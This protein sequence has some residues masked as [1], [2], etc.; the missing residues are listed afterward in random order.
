MTKGYRMGKK[1]GYVSL[2][3]A[4]NLVD[5]E[6]MLGLLRDNGYSITEDLSEADLIV[7]NTCT[8]IEKA[9]AES[10]NT[11]LEVAQYKEDGTCKGLIV[12]G[13]LSQQYQDELFQEIPEIDALIGTGA[14]DQVMVA[15][16]AIEH[17]N[18]SCIM[19]NITNIYDERM[20][21]IQTTPRYSAYVKIA[22][23]CNN[24]CTFCIPQS[25]YR[26]Y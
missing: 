10:I 25:Y 9:K 7:V 4:K 12:A 11:I 20:P 21:R 17:G 16:D 19:E 22:E 18:R 3:C 8:F 5:T 1:L 23:G 2:G 24:G 13:C 6:V 14:W 26:V 15:V